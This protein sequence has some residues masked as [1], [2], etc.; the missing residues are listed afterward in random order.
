M[1]A[2][3]ARRPRVVTIGGGHGQAALLSALVKLEC[4]ITAIASV[5]DDGGCSGQLRD[6]FDM[7]PPGDLRRCL[8]TLARDRVLAERFE[9]RLSDAN[10]GKRSA[11]NLALLEAFEAHGSLQAAVDWAATL[12]SC[13]GRVLAAAERPGRLAI[14]DRAAGVVEG[15]THIAEVGAF[16]MVVSVHGPEVANPLAL[17]AVMAAELVFLGPGSFITSTLAAVMTGNLGEALAATRAR[18]VFVHNLVD[19]PGQTSGFGLDDYARLLR[20]HLCIASGVS[21]VPLTVMRHGP[22]AREE[23]GPGGYP[24]VVAPVADA[25]EPSRHDPERLATAIAGAFGLTPLADDD[26]QPPASA[27]ARVFNEHLQRALAALGYGS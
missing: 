10:G 12:L 6:Q 24:I 4:E 17:E 18:R 9:V 14:Y 3:R 8:T 22:E 27:P 23:R 7:P 21:D 26:D 25:F 16:P 5:A 11:G 15:E 19:E 1:M 2:M 13:R 20:D